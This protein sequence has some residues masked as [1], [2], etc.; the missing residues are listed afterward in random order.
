MDSI[1]GVA[2]ATRLEARILWMNSLV[3]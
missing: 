2:R 1:G 3:K